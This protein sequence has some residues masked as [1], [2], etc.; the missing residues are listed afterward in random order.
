MR[1]GNPYFF[2]HNRCYSEAWQSFCHL[3]QAQ[4]E[5]YGGDGLG[6]WQDEPLSR[7]ETLVLCNIPGLNYEAWLC[8]MVYHTANQ[9]AVHIPEIK[10]DSL[11]IGRCTWLMSSVL[12]WRLFFFFLHWT[13]NY[14]LSPQDLWGTNTR[15]TCQRLPSHSP[16]YIFIPPRIMHCGYDTAQSWS[17]LRGVGLRQHNL[18]VNYD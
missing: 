12:S 5:V 17:F 4:T 3:C 1:P 10:A 11:V 15:H 6:G 8:I 13:E 18:G 16:M 2:I 14:L 9:G 7:S